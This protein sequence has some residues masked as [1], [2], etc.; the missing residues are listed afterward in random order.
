MNPYRSKGARRLLSSSLLCLSLLGGGL[1]SSSCGKHAHGMKELQEA[2]HYYYND[3]RWSRLSAAAARMHPDIRES[4]V[5]DWTE[6]GQELQ[7]Q[8]LEIVDM[9]DDLEHDKARVTLLVSWVER[10]SMQLRSATVTQTWLRTDDGWMAAD[11][12]ELPQG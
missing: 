12:L 1:L 7:L 11:T 4:F 3:L 2:T 6:R 8:D 9:Q 5:A 10:S